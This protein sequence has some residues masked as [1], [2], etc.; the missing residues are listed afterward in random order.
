MKH[1]TVNR[2]VVG[3]NPTAGA[4]Q[5]KSHQDKHQKHSATNTG[6]CTQKCTQRRGGVVVDWSREVEALEAELESAL[7]VVA[8]LEEALTFAKIALAGE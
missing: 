4:N 3:S 2:T 7:A 8:D 1:P 5:T 6:W